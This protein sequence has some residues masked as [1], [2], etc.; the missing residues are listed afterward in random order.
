CNNRKSDCHPRD[1]K[2]IGMK[3]RAHPRVPTA[4]E[5]QSVARRYPTINIHQTWEQFL[6][7]EQSISDGEQGKQYKA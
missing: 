3:L 5:L 4:Y 7:Y 2:S 1:L 6:Y